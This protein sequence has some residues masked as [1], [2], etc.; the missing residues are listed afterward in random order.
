VR[1][2]QGIIERNLMRYYLVLK[3]FL[4]TKTVPD[5]RRFEARIST[6][7]DLM[8][9]YPSQLHEMERAEYLDAKRRERQNQIRLQQTI[10]PTRPQPTG[11]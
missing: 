9:R 2:A 4:D 10:G 7:Y 1:G 5:S 11:P 8:E 3:A 6:F